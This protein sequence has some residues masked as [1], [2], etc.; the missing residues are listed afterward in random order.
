MK[1]CFTIGHVK[2][3]N[4]FFTKKHFKKK[5]TLKTKHYFTMKT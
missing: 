1:H 5:E 2:G 4:I 3:N